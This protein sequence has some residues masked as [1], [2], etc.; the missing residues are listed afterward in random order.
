MSDTPR[1]DAAY[2]ASKADDSARVD[3]MLACGET[4]ERENA[5]LRKALELAKEQLEDWEVTIDGEWGDCRS[6][7][8]LKT[9]GQLSKAT[10]AVC[11]A[12]AQI[13]GGE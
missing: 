1:I 3:A 6:L 2:H 13:G 11:A 9:D 5:A 8:R 10:L 12:L 7:E 4:L